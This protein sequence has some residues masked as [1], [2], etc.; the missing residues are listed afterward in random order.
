MLD[1]KSNIDIL[2]NKITLVFVR[3]S[4]FV[5]AAATQRICSISIISMTITYAFISIMYST[6]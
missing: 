2:I 1:R 6:I 4:Y 3:R 5:W